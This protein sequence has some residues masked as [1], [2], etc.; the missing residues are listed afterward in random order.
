MN[1]FTNF[2]EIIKHNKNLLYVNHNKKRLINKSASMPFKVKK[3]AETDITKTSLTSEALAELQT[4]NE[5]IEDQSMYLLLEKEEEPSINESKL[6]KKMIKSSTYLNY[7]LS[8]EPLNSTKPSEFEQ[9][10]NE[11]EMDNYVRLPINLEI[12]TTSFQQPPQTTDYTNKQL[13]TE[14]QFNQAFIQNVNRSL[15]ITIFN[16]KYEIYNIR[17]PINCY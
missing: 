9:I 12:E 10:D 15:F 2:N 17:M 11:I 7:L 1:N 6:A 13:I 3:E 14:E 16:L 5:I 8:N 4:Q